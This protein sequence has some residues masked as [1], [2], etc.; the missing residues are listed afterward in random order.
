MN[1]KPMIFVNE[2]L[3][4]GVYAA[5]GSPATT[6]ITYNL[7]FNGVTGNGWEQYIINFTNNSDT[8]I[9]TATV[10]LTATGNVEIVKFQ[11]DGEKEGVVNLPFVT[12]TCTNNTNGF[13]AHT[14]SKD[15][16]LQVKGNGVFS[17]K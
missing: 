3:S 15:F 10:T 9:G 13:K 17:L 2:D 6:G 1:V 5:S 8:F 7:R 11:G 12:L 16:L 4:E 14:T